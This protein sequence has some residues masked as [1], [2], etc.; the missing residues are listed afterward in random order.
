MMLFLDDRPKLTKTIRGNGVLTAVKEADNQLVSIN[1]YPNPTVFEIVVDL[2]D[3]PATTAKQL[4]IRNAT[5]QI[6]FSET[7]PTGLNEYRVKTDKFI[8]GVYFVSVLKEND[9]KTVKIL[10][11]K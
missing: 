10:I 11:Q 2:K 1:I 3:V 9:V 4:E 8:S 7:L 6:V 5:G